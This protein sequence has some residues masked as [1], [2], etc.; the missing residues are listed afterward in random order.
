MT[1]WPISAAIAVPRP[2]V[3]PEP[4]TSRGGHVRLLVEHAFDRG[5]VDRL[6]KARPRAVRVDVGAAGK[7]RRLRPVA[8]RRHGNPHQ[9]R[10]HG[11]LSSNDGDIVTDWALQGLGV[12]MRSEW[13]I[14]SHLQSGALVRVLPGVPTPPADIHALL[15]DDVHVP[16]RISELAEHLAARLPDRISGLSP[17]E[18]DLSADAV[19]RSSPLFL[20]C[21]RGR[22]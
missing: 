12:I 21:S 16:R 8:L 6:E 2:L 1:L 10:V 5:H 17:R 14:Q 13:Q 3:V 18:S 4:P 22:P 7:R 9:V 19:V 15:P 11:R 20:G